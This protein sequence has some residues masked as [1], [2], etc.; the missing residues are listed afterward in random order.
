[1]SVKPKPIRSIFAP[2]LTW[3]LAV[4]LALVLT[5]GIGVGARAEGEN[6]AAHPPV[7]VELFVSQ[8]CS[9][10]PAAIDLFPAYATREDVVALS[11]HVDYWNMTAS[12]NG[13]WT[14]PLSD[15]AF[16][17]RQKKYN[18]ALRQRSS[19]Y[20]PQAIVDG[21]AE[22]VGSSKSKISTLIEQAMPEAKKTLVTASENEG[23]VTFDVSESEDGGNAYLVTFKREV[24]TTVAK[25]ANAGATFRQVNVVTHMK[26]LGIVR[27]HGEQFSVAAPDHVNNEGCALIVQ[28]PPQARII[29]A[30]YCP[31]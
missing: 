19:I 23:L 5:S 31:L 27:R 1:M 4:A 12:R 26:P 20:T 15:A 8:S 17:K 22:T 10:C 7:V 2:G 3:K 13:V 21:A 29:A 30:A 6:I 24:K 16:T 28:E 14:D 25:G 9:R 18:M 11:W